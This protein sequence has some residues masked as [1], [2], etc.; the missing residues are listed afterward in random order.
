MTPGITQFVGLNA[1]AA[2]TATWNV[3]VS[4]ERFVTF[5]TREESLPPAKSPGTSR[6]SSWTEYR[7]AQSTSP[8]PFS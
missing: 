2:R 5:T 6:T 7:A 1:V 8:P 4:F 3:R